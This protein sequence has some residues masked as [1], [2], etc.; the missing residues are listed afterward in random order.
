MQAS[1][2]LAYDKRIS[3]IHSLPIVAFL[4]ISYQSVAL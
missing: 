3:F 4:K 2:E 1:V